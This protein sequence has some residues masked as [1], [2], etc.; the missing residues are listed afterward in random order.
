MSNF[1]VDMSGA[2]PVPRL[3]NLFLARELAKDEVGRST[4]PDGNPLVVGTPWFMAPEQ[5]FNSVTVDQRADLW[6]VGCLLYGLLT[7][8]RPFADGVR[9]DGV[10]TWDVVTD[11][12]NLV[13]RGEYLPVN[14]HLPSAPKRMEKAIAACLEVEVEDRVADATTLLEL[15]TAGSDA[16]VIASERPPSGEVALVFTDVAGSTVLWNSAPE[17]MRHALFAHNALLRRVLRENGGYEVKTEGD[18]FMIAF[19][20]ALDGL[21]FCVEAQQALYAHAWAAD[22]LSEAPAEQGEQMRGLRVRMGLHMGMVQSQPDP[23]TGRIDYFGPTVNEAARIEGLARGGQI[24]ASDVAWAQ[25]GIRVHDLA[26][27][28]ELGRFHLKGF[29]TPR[30]LIEVQS[31]KL[32]RRDFPVPDGRQG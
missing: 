4:R 27:G 12:F 25:C 31:P 15:W 24:L 11:I 3:A 7:G 32:L 23:T 13:R 16:P 22:L 17:A 8:K 2:E 9:S 20:S 6:S 18:S 19:A 10:P 1:M 30:G 21:R 26:I 5:T 29:D 14:V 28:A